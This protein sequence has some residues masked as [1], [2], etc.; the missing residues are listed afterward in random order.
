MRQRVR[1]LHSLLQVF[2]VNGPTDGPPART[3]KPPSPEGAEGA[4]S[5][6]VEAGADASATSAEAAVAVDEGWEDWEE[7]HYGW[8]PTRH[9]LRTRRRAAEAARE[10]RF[11]LEAQGRRSS[12]GRSRSLFG[13]FIPGQILE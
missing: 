8:C 2:A 10:A 12:N 1:A 11:L 9:R 7:E 6:G 5:A 4:E 13:S 3:N